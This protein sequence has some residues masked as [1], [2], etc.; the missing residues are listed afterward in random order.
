MKVTTGALGMKRNRSEPFGTV[1]S[2][3]T[4]GRIPMKTDAELLD[5]AKRLNER[6]GR[7]PR[8]Q[9]LVGQAG[10]C[11][12]QRAVRAIQTL[13]IEIA[14]KAVR[15]QLMIPAV[16]QDELKTVFARWL[17][18]AAT[19]LA[20]KHAEAEHKL[21]QRLDAANEAVFEKNDRIQHLQSQLADAEHLQQELLARSHQLQGSLTEIT[22]ERDQAVA[23]ARERQRVLDTLLRTEA[24]KDA[25]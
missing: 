1:S 21:E 8:T 12:R 25:G 20:E 17:D 22:Q 4:S 11:Q 19:Q 15:S 13:R 18:C 23:L 6:L 10:G 3:S 7:P 5:L 2:S 24:A 14:E 16:L 9:E